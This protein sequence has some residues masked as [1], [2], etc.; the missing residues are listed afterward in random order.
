MRNGPA[1]RS[2]LV[3]PGPTACVPL[4]MIAPVLQEDLFRSAEVVDEAPPTPAA[5]KAAV[6]ERFAGDSLSVL[7][8]FAGMGGMSLGFSRAG[9]K[10]LGVD[11]Q[12]WTAPVFEHN[13]IGEVRTRDL[14]TEGVFVDATVVTGGPPCRPWSA[15]NTR[16]RREDHP[17]QPL[18]GRYYEHVLAILPAVFLM[19]NVPAVQADPAYQMWWRRMQREGYS[20]GCDLF[21]YASYGAATARQRLFTIGIRNS[22]TG[23]LEFLTRMRARRC[24]AATVGDA[25]KH[26][27]H[28]PAGSPPD[29]VWP[30]LK[31][32][33][34]YAERYE[35]GQY[36]WRRLTMEEAAPSFGNVTKTYVLHP[37]SAP[38][39]PAARVLSVRELLL[40][41]GFGE[42]F[43][44]P[45][46]VPLTVQYQMLADCVSPIFSRVTA[47]V[48]RDML[49][50]SAAG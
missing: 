13:A 31:T 7:D 38:D 41:M 34:S 19:E 22:R 15:I 49:V 46:A 44:F 43:S 21:T 18:L 20:M 47:E 10:V 8:L 3:C 32:I 33:G 2:A 1:G 35:T 12:Q 45:P 14:A 24:I 40:I 16:L 48:I 36:G 25:I 50:K 42:S 30:D 9:F 39:D 5:G 23:A 26:L 17:D 28:Q 11:V 37:D 6:L 27:R 29:H 4:V